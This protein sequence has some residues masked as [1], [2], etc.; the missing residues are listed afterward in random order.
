MKGKNMRVLRVLLGFLSAGWLVPLMIACDNLLQYLNHDLPELLLKGMRLGGIKVNDAPHVVDAGQLLMLSGLWLAAVILVWSFLLARRPQGHLVD[1][2]GAQRL[3]ENESLL[4]RQLRAL[5]DQLELHRAAFT[6]QVPLGSD[7]LAGSVVHRLSL[8][9]ARVGALDESLSHRLREMG[10]QVGQL[11]R[12]G[13]QRSSEDRRLIEKALIDLGERMLGRVQSLDDT[14][15]FLHTTSAEQASTSALQHEKVQQQLHRLIDQSR[16]PA[17]VAVDQH[18]SSDA[19]A[20]SISELGQRLG[21]V[22]DML[23]KLRTVT[24]STSAEVR[25]V[26]LAAQSGNSSWFGDLQA[27]AAGASVD[28]AARLRDVVL[29]L[30]HLQ[31]NLR[32]ERRELRKRLQGLQAPAA[33]VV[34]VAAPAAIAGTPAAP[35]KGNIARAA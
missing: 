29:N 27:G 9:E 1:E 11:V 34:A 31:E 32:F 18:D 19:L 30:S 16:A 8:M 2:G 7:P 4:Y 15:G 3:A 21:H 33:P 13:Q 6:H 25:D 23:D 24:V 12:G 17:P 5:G 35:T 26:R 14:L 10:D 20:L 28:E 22:E